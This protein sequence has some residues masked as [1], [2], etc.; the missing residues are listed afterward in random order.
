MTPR[1][2]LL[3]SHRTSYGRK[4]DAA[5]RNLQPFRR[6]KILALNRESQATVCLRA[7][8]RRCL[9]RNGRFQSC[10]RAS[11]T[12]RRVSSRRAADR[13]CRCRRAA[14]ARRQ[15]LRHLSQRAAEDRRSG[16]RQGHRRSGARRRS[17]GRLG[18]GDSEAARRHDAAA[19]RCRGPTKPTID[20][21]VVV[22][23]N[24]IDRAALAKPNPGRSPLHR[25]NRTEYANAIRDLL[26]LDID[27]TALLPADDEANGFDNIA[28][29]LKVSPSLLEQYLT[30]SRKISGLA[31]GDPRIDAGQRGVSRAAGS[32]RRKITS[33]ACRSAR[34]AASSSGTTSRSTP[35]T[36]SASSCCRTSSATCRASSGRTSSR[37][38]IDGERVFLRRSAATQTTS[39]RT[40]TWRWRR[41]RSTSGLRT[42]VPVK[43][44]PHV[45][46]VTF[47]AQELGAS[48]TSR[49]SRSRAISTCRT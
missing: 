23:R 2:A 7:R 31:V 49:C 16:A 43:A 29:V 27:A 22:S 46:G 48:R 33:K 38:P 14:R 12:A 30:A 11:A 17:R 41:R 8:R 19:G 39:C 40:R 10:T 20:A 37:S 18:K 21:F 4:F 13:D 5:E 32:R 34:A 25:L 36:T 45:V 28:D 35:T 1:T 15:V 47:I 42:R 24:S 26:A 6:A 3:R 44:G 9:V